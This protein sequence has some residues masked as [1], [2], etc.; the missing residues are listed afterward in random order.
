MGGANFI[1]K[2]REE[3]TNYQTYGPRAEGRKRKA[4]RM[5]YQKS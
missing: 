1:M 2:G 3:S 4:G 5:Q